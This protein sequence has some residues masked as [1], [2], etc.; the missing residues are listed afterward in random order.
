MGGNNK[1][2]QLQMNKKWKKKEGVERTCPV[3][4]WPPSFIHHPLI[5]ESYH[6][7]Q[8]VEKINDKNDR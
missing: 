7:R 5:I 4:D 1:V 2:D 8:A 6:C 3:D